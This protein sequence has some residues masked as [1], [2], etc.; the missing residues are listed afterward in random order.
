MLQWQPCLRQEFKPTNSQEG[1]LLVNRVEVYSFQKRTPENYS[2][3]PSTRH[4]FHAHLLHVTDYL[5]QH[6]DQRFPF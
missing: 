1:H 3:I 5:Q 6:H 4:D 2:F